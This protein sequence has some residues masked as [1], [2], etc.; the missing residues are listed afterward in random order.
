MVVHLRLP[1]GP[2]CPV[3]DYHLRDHHITH[4]VVYALL[5]EL[6]VHHEFHHPVGLYL[7]MSPEDNVADHDI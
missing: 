3:L 4:T 7:D 2:K 1:Y 6:D 5:H